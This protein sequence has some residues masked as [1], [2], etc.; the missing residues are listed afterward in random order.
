MLGYGLLPL[1]IFWR[2]YSRNFTWSI[3]EYFVPYHALSSAFNLRILVDSIQL[4]AV[5]SGKYHLTIYSRIIR[6][7]ALKCLVSRKKKSRS[8]INPLN[9]SVALIKTSQL[10]LSANRLTDFYMSVTLAFNR[11]KYLYCW[12]D[13]F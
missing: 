12:H 10:T 1:Q 4:V 9:A 6:T 3:H 2:L 7:L 8:T 13:K 11:L 5:K